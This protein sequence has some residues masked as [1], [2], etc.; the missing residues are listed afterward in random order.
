MSDALYQFGVCLQAQGVDQFP[1]LLPV[2]GGDAQLYQLVRV[3]GD[4][5]LGAHGIADARGADAHHWIQMVGPSAQGAPLFC[6]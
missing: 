1:A 3:Q 4:V 5:E 6:R 2:I